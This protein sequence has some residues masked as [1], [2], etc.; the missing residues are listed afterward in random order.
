MQQVFFIT[1]CLLEIPANIMLK[2][3]P[4]SRWIGCLVVAW[5]AVSRMTCPS[6]SVTLG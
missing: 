4:P 2:I 6:V 3:L 5:G 1:Y